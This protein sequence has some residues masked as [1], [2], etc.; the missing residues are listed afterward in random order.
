VDKSD[1]L[2]TNKAFMDFI[3]PHNDDLPYLYDNYDWS[4]CADSYPVVTVP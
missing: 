1:L 4:H 3:H 2:Y